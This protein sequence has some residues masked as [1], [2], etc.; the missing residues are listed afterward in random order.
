MNGEPTRDSPTNR[1]VG[2]HPTRARKGRALPG[3]PTDRVRRF[4]LPVTAERAI[5]HN[6]TFVTAFQWIFQDRLWGKMRQKA[7]GRSNKF[8]NPAHDKKEV[9]FKHFHTGGDSHATATPPCTAAGPRRTDLGGARAP[10]ARGGRESGPGPG[11]AAACKGA[12][13][14]VSARDRHGIAVALD[15]R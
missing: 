11:A 10:S 14:L 5:Y 1:C 12:A 2:L 9:I 6:S 15:Q 13:Q 7:G 8:P 3:V 4:S